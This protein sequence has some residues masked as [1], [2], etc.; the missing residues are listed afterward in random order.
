MKT[1]KAEIK[2]AKAEAKLAKKEKHDQAEFS[3]RAEAAEKRLA[4][5]KALEE[6]E[7]AIE[8]D[9][10][11]RKRKKEELVAAA[12]EKIDRD[13]ARRVI[14]DRLH[15]LLVQTYQGY[16]RADQRACFAA[17]ENLHEKYAVTAKA[18][19]AKRDTEAAKLNTFRGVGV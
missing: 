8:G 10:V 6:E 7:P 2:E 14:L 16:L 18:I 12:R 3:A 5:H 1:L 11:R 19:E 17:L 15:R 9:S 4:R 13:E